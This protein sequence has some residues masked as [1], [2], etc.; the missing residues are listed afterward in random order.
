VLGGG[1]SPGF[2]NNHNP[3][4]K[5][6]KG[7]KWGKGRRVAPIDYNFFFLEIFVFSRLKEANLLSISF[8]LKV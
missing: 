4:K 6:K 5:K 2:Y 7:K 8:D 1:P 3:K